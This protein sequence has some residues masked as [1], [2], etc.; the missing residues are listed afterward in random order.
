L[1]LHEYSDVIPLEWDRVRVEENGRFK[2]SLGKCGTD[3][4]HCSY[5]HISWA[6]YNKRS[7]SWERMKETIRHELVHAWQARWLG[8]TSHGP[9]FVETAEKVDCTGLDRYDE[10]EPRH[11]MVCQNCGSSYT[12][13]RKCKATR[14]TDFYKCRACEMVESRFNDSHRTGGLWNHY[15]NTDWHKVL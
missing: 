14:R 3:G 4:Y 12:R 2:R 10:P 7:Y 5:I 11:V 1:A 6:H 8:Y 9:T 15:H 13:Q